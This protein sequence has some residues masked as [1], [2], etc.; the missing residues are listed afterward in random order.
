MKRLKIIGSVLG[1]V[2]L[3]GVVVVVGGGFAIDPDVS[4]ETT[5]EIAA[6]PA[7]VVRHLSS[8]EGL[9]AWW[10]V[11]QDETP[12]GA[13]RMTVQKQ[14]GPDQ[15]EGLVVTFEAG[16]SVMET[17]TVRHV[18]PERVEYEVDFAGMLTVH[19]TLTLAGAGERLRVTWR[20]T[21]RIDNPVSRWMKVMMPAEE[22]VK[23][24]DAALGALERAAARPGG[25]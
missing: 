22:I 2:V 9:A 17:W 5:R 1:A 7:S 12:P 4:L 13:P 23:N 3:L 25:A 21:G 14:A 24:F 16:G 15:G 8:A 10:K 20:E 6:G 19:R 18:S 11:A